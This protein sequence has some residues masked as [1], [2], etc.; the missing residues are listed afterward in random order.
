MS[1]VTLPPSFSKNIALWGSIAHECAHDIVGAYDGLLEECTEKV[2]SEITNSR[3][4]QGHFVEYN[5][6]RQP[7]PIRAAEVWK[8]WMN[9]T[10]AD[11]LG[12]LNFGPASGIALASLLIPLRKGKLI[13]DGIPDDVHPIDAIRI[14]LAA[15]L[16]REIPSLNSEIANNWADSFTSIID[17]YISNKSSFTLSRQT[18]TGPIP[19]IVFPFEEMKDTCKI[20]AKT[21]AFS[22]MSTLLNHSF[23]EIN[24]WTDMHE[25]TAIRIAEELL[26]KKEPS[27]EAKTGE[28]K[29]YPA[30]IVSG[31]VIALSNSP[32]TSEITDLAISALNKSYDRNPVWQGYPIVFKSDLFIHKFFHS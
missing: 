23:N 32:K 20:V 5:G 18:S 28:A 2:Y 12:I 30:H 11:V 22:P 6:R 31:A 24:T 21:L 7:L 25:S 10:I 8:Y 29:V 13:T 15:D 16:I 1:V 9:E 26:D 27:F 14:F 3:E 4:L 19:T 17:K